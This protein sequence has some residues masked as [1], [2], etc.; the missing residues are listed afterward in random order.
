M[1]E[2][3]S[4]T[5]SDPDIVTVI[6]KDNSGLWPMYYDLEGHPKRMGY[7][8]LDPIPECPEYILEEAKRII[9]GE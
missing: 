9:K 1:P 5:M 7:W 8:S 6:W 4:F 3:Y 2:V